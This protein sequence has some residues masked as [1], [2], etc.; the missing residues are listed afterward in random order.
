MTIDDQ[1]KDEKL[2]YNI[3][4]EA[5]KISALSSGKFNKYEYLTGEEV[6]P[7]NNQQIIEQAKFEYSPLGKAFEKQVKTIEDQGKKQIQALENLKLKEITRD[8]TKPIEY[9][10]YFI[11]ELAKI[12]K[13]IKPVDFNNL[14][15][16]C[17]GSNEP[18]NCSEYKGM[19]NIFKSIHS[20]DKTLEDIEQEKNK[21]KK[22]I[23]IVKQGN[24]KKRSVKQQE[25][26]DNIENLYK[27]RQEVVNMFN[28]Y[29]KNVSKSIHEAKHEGKGLKI[30]TSN[31]M[32]KRLPIALAQIKAGNNSESLL[33]EIRQIV[34]YLYRSKKITKML[35][36]NII[37]SIKA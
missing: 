26:I 16:Y 34:Y 20:G 24:P 29:A 25:E 3:N 6:L 12:Q 7:S 10:N 11:N 2:Q 5:A 28:N 33:N 9:N 15:Y 18:I 13:S 19:I 35:Y 30:L 22:E 37:N 21:F 32:F 23:A 14:I 8:K 4:R 1:I 27:S 31:Q 36:N 17:K